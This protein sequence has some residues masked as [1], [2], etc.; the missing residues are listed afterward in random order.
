MLTNH[1]TNILVP[2]YAYTGWFQ[3][4]VMSHAAPV[5][6]EIAKTTEKKRFAEC[7]IGR[8]A[9]VANLL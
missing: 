5:A 6:T 7:M 4:S 3:P 2:E 9:V 8:P 1:F